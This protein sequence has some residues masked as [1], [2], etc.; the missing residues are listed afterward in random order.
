MRECSRKRSTIET[1]SMFVADARHAGPQR[2]DAAHVQPDPDAGLRR[3]V[4]RLDDLLVDERV[5]LGDDLR[6]LARLG[7]AP[8]AL[9][10]PQEPPPQAGRRHH[11]L[12]QAR[13]IGVAGQRVEE[14][15]RVLGDRLRRR[16]QAEVGVD[17]RGPLVVVAG[18]E[19]HVA[20]QAL[21]RCAARSGRSS[22]AS[23]SRGRRR[24]RA[25]RPPRARAPSGCCAPRRSAPSARR[26]R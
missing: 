18:A 8:L 21:R 19:V 1:T 6:R 10:Q 16:H 7:A 12:L 14:R 20:P 5:H 4:E 9:D 22:R 13:R 11:Q 3:R 24:S 2:A 15:G 23:C 26:A 25:R 17:A